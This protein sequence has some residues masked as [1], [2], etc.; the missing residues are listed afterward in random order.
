VVDPRLVNP[1]LKTRQHIQKSKSISKSRIFL[2]SQDVRSDSPASIHADGLDHPEETLLEEEEEEADLQDRSTGSDD[3]PEFR[4]LNEAMHAT[5]FL[6]FYGHLQNLSFTCM[7][8]RQQVS[9][10]VSASQV[11]LPGSRSSA[12]LILLLVISGCEA[13][14]AHDRSVMLQRL[15][16]CGVRRFVMWGGFWSC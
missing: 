5:E 15:Q 6:L 14:S 12:A 11:I 2:E 9:R 7:L 16:G 4:A 10:I 3:N 13:V 8:I 1:L